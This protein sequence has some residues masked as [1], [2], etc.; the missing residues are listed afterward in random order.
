[1]TDRITNAP[2]PFDL[3]R[4]RLTAMLHRERRMHHVTAIVL[5]VTAIAGGGMVGLAMHLR[6][7]NT[8]LRERIDIEVARSGGRVSQ[9]RL[10]HC[11]P[12]TDGPPG[13]L[14]CWRID[15]E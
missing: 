2:H 3:D 12:A 15:A 14:V 13:S 5:I 9:S 8:E 1:M 11:Y 6:A 7:E 4:E 10:T